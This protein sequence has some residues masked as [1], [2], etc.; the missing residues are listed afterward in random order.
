M[1]HKSLDKQRDFEKLSALQAHQAW[2]LLRELVVQDSY[3]P[4]GKLLRVGLLRD[5][6]SKKDRAL[7]DSNWPEARYYQ[8]RK[9]E[10]L[11][12]IEGKLFEWAKDK[13]TGEK[14]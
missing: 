8:G 2:E 14:Q 9:D 11:N 12:I 6:E 1:P 4:Q 13:L 5:L 3:S 7:R 10:L